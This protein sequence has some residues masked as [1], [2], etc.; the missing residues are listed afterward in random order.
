MSRAETA[1]ARLVK[2]YNKHKIRVTHT[3][4][5][6]IKWITL[7]P[8]IIEHATDQLWPELSDFGL[9]KTIERWNADLAKDNFDSIVSRPR[10]PPSLSILPSTAD[11][12]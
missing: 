1:A 3:K 4:R 6:R 10:T 5:E 7:L 11:H 9:E 8:K 12:S 2:T